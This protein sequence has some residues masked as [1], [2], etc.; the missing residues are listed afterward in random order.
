MK[1]Y[2]NF[3]I[4]QFNEY[5]AERLKF[6]KSLSIFMYKYNSNFNVYFLYHI[7]RNLKKIKLNGIN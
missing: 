5:Y 4:S 2:H 3:I 7:S 6:L 1:F